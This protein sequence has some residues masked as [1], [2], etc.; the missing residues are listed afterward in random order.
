MQLAMDEAGTQSERIVLLASGPEAQQ[1]LSRECAAVLNGQTPLVRVGGV[2][3]FV[4]TLSKGQA[5]VVVLE[6]AQLDDTDLRQI[7]AALALQPAAA[8][9]LVLP[10]IGSDALLH[11]MRAGVREVVL[12]Q[13][14]EGELAAAIRRQ[15]ER[16]RGGAGRRRH[17]QIW[18]FM[19][20]KGG[21]GATFLA[22]NLA[23][24]LAQ[25]SLRVAIF[26]LNLQF[27]DV[28]L[29]ITDRR[30]SADLAS[31]CRELE[32]LDG[33]LLE[34]SMVQVSS[35]LWVLGAPVTPE[36]ALDVGPSAL[37]RLVEVA[38]TQFDVVVLDLGRVVDATTLQ[39]LDESDRVH[40]VLQMALPTLHGASRL[41][42]V[43]DRLGHGGAKLRLV[44]NRV[45]R[46]CEIGATQVRRAL[47]RDLAISVPNSYRN[48]AAAVNRGQP[49]LEAHP[50]D[51]V[52]RRLVQWAESIKPLPQMRK[53]WLRGFLSPR[54]EGSGCET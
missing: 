51:P 54:T 15:M 3:A 45:D 32:R 24:A 21:S 49:I 9:V 6:L 28:P 22:T 37:Q 20:A 18:A 16:G 52:A 17:G 34:S 38:R 2:A 30:G 40:M 43:L 8:L 35:T 41:L 50:R 46:G 7:E 31:V 13:A 36:R 11:A 29:F 25:R 42:A 14:P 44:A 19:P 26:D 53:G 33:P 1:R 48:V 27:G 23:Y 47:G 5:D 4:A 12:T 39:A 10:K